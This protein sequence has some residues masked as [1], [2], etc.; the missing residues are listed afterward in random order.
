MLIKFLYK[1]WKIPQLIHLITIALE[2]YTW[3]DEFRDDWFLRCIGGKEA[4]AIQLS[5]YL[6]TIP[7]NRR[8]F[9]PPCPILKSVSS[10]IFPQKKLII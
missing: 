10:R 4:A 6:K 8:C 9:L 5:F 2:L 1:D 3:V 7:V